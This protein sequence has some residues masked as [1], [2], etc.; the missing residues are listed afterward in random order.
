MEMGRVVATEVKWD[1]GCVR[2]PY[3]AVYDG[4]QCLGQAVC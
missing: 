4:G 2:H 1:G 3:D